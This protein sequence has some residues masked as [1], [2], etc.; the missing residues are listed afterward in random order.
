M[1]LPTAQKITL[2][3]LFVTSPNCGGKLDSSWFFFSG[4]LSC[5]PLFFEPVFNVGFKFSH[6]ARNQNPNARCPYIICWCTSRAP[7]S[8][9]PCNYFCEVCHE[10]S[11]SYYLRRERSK[12]SARCQVVNSKLRAF[13][14]DKLRLSN[15]LLI[16]AS[17]PKIKS[18][19]RP[20]LPMQKEP[21]RYPGT[22]MRSIKEHSI[23]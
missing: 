21:K 10:N 15:H 1:A 20:K 14:L 12:Q 9:C 23:T 11:L 5:V 2:V 16:V 19:V 18:V 4:G 13:Q 22:G 17:I 7:W 3:I 8:I 6:R